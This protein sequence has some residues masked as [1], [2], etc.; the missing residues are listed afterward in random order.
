M[1][2]ITLT[3]NNEMQANET[4]STAFTNQDQVFFLHRNTIRQELWGK[5]QKET[6]KNLNKK[7]IINREQQTNQQK[8]KQNKTKQNKKNVAENPKQTQHRKRKVSLL[9]FMVVM[10]VAAYFTCLNPANIF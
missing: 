7:K 1:W 6:N 3:N 5:Q 9:E 8:T 2:L 10:V 4:E